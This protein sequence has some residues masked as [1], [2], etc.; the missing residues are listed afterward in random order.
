MAV[1]E[2]E[3]VKAPKPVKATVTEV[4]YES[5]EKEPTMFE[6]AEY[7][8][9]RNFSSGRLEWVVPAHDVERFEQHFFIQTGRI[10]RKG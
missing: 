5:R 1:K 10:V 7:W 4:V 6:A 2:P 9:S 3:A 8:P